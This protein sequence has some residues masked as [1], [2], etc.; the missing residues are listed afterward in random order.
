MVEGK[1]SSSLEASSN[2]DWISARS[3]GVRWGSW[4]RKNNFLSPP[5]NADERRSCMRFYLRLSAFIGGLFFLRSRQEDRDAQLMVV[6]R[7]IAVGVVHVLHIHPARPK[8]R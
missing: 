5:M 2:E 6:A 3:S 8:L 7:A 4:G 1:C